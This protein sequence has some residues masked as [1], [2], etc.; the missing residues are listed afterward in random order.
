MSYN[1]ATHNISG[2]ISPFLFGG[3]QM[4]IF[5]HP[6]TFAGI[7]CINNDEINGALPP[8]T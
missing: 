5:L 7:S 6:A 8:G 4:I 2:A 3:V 1:F